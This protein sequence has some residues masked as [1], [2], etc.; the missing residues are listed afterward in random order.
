MS[1]KLFHLFLN[2]NINSYK[3]KALPD[4]GLKKIVENGSLPQHVQ[5]TIE[6]VQRV[7]CLFI[8]NDLIFQNFQY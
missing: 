2:E 6:N 8:G 7:P 4:T 5:K 3:S 1:R